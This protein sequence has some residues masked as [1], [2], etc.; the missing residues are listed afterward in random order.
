MIILFFFFFLFSFSIFSTISDKHVFR[1]FRYVD[2]NG[3]GLNI[4]SLYAFGFFKLSHF[5]SYSKF[6]KY[7]KTSF[8]R[9]SRCMVIIDVDTGDNNIEVKNT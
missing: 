6:V 8:I 7:S 4:Q 1:N 3:I 9:L 5:Y 2:L